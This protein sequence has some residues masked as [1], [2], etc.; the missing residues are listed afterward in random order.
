[1][2]GVISY[3]PA[4]LDLLFRGNCLSREDSGLCSG[5][6]SNSSSQLVSNILMPEYFI[7]FVCNN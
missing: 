7:L 4:Y 2:I 1:M 5:V 3:V 6:D